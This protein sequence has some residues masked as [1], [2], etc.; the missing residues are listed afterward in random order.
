M[1]LRQAVCDGELT[2]DESAQTK[3]VHKLHSIYL[4]ITFLNI[5]TCDLEGPNAW[6]EKMSAVNF[7]N[8]G[9]MT[10]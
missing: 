2:N 10:K 4:V 1:L 3:T 7:R 8:F 5:K 9:C 6:K